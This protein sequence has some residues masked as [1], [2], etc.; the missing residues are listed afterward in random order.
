MFRV[1]SGTESGR[2]IV[3]RR[4][5]GWARH[6]ARIVVGRIASWVLAEKP[7]INRSLGKPKGRYEYNI[8]SRTGLN[9]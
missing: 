2:F 9:N 3:Y 4:P 5:V 1:D 6:V 8:T 7:D